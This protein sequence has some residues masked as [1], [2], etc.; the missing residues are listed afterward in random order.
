MQMLHF[1]VQN[2]PNVL[3]SKA[4]K[5][6]IFSRLLILDIEDNLNLGST[7]YLY[8]YVADTRKKVKNSP[9]SVMHSPK[10]NGKSTHAPQN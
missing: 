7:P 10:G 9:K 1:V 5:A 8:G 3:R 6:I 4:G 2:Q